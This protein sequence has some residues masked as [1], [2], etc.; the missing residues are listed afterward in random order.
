MEL[1]RKKGCFI[2]KKMAFVKISNGRFSFEEVGDAYY[3]ISILKDTEFSTEDLEQIVELE[4]EAGGRRLPVLVVCHPSTT[5]NIELMQ[6]LSKNKNNPYSSADA[7]VIH[8]I[9]QKIL[10]NFYL[11]INRPER[12][13]QFFNNEASALAWLKQYM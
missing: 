8:S 2:F 4:K 5:T 6:K 1:I 11:K 13:T 9:S 7:F 12:P 10:A 3:L